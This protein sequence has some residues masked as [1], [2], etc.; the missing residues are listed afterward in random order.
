MENTEIID[1]S[2][3]LQSQKRKIDATKKQIRGSSLLLLGRFISIGLN[4]AT[5]V[6]MVRY[7]STTDYGSWGYALA[8]VNFFE[9]FSTLGLKRSISRFIPIYHENEEYEKL[10]GTI[11]LVFMTIVING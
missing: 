2:I 11:A 9:V 10:F 1:T 3:A 5:Q 4:F 7:L 8:L 6:M